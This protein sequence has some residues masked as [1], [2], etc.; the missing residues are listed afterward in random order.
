[1]PTV[2]PVI[3]DVLRKHV[4]DVLCKC[5]L[6]SELWL[7]I[8]LCI[9]W[10][11]KLYVEKSWPPQRSYRELMMCV[12]L[13]IE[14]CVLIRVRMG[15]AKINWKSIYAFSDSLQFNWEH[16]VEYPV[17]Q[18]PIFCGCFCHRNKVLPCLFKYFFELVISKGIGNTGI[19]GTGMGLFRPMVCP[20]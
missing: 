18:I 2:N 7:R 11:I 8:I 14:S 1:M 4:P 17:K 5:K 6:H 16:P 13:V 9:F 12:L 19:P 20:P 10:R 3:R 15:R